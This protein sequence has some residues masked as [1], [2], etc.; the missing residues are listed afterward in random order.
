VWKEWSDGDFGVW[1]LNHSPHERMNEAN[2]EHQFSHITL[3][4]LFLHRCFSLSLEK[5]TM[6]ACETWRA[7]LCYASSMACHCA[8]NAFLFS[9][10]RDFFTT[11]HIL[12]KPSSTRCRPF[13]LSITNAAPSYNTLVSEVPF[14]F[15]FHEFYQYLAFSLSACILNLMASIR[16]FFFFFCYV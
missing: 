14:L 12:Y 1:G 15:Y 7:A 3:L 6:V 11:N 5:K 10:T 13:L 2:Q 4:S 16:E 8:H 9:P